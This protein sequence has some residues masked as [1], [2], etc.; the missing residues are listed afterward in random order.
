MNDLNHKPLIIKGCR[1]CGKTASVLKFAKE[2]YKHVVY[3]NF[4]ENK[5]YSSIFS[6]SLE[7]DH[8]TMMM[9]ALL[10]KEAVF[11]KNKTII[12]LDEIQE[13]PEARTA[14]KFFCLDKRYDVICTGSLLGVSGYKTSPTSIPV[15]YE[16]IIDMYPMDFEEFLWANDIN[17]EII[18]LLKKCLIEENVI[19]QAIHDR[20][21]QLLLQYITVGGMPEVV[22]SFVNNKN[23]NEV[24]N[25]QRN[26]IRSYS[27]DML[28]YADNK[29]KGCIKECFE[30]I[31]K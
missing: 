14:L 27:D 22:Q 10:G 11:E 29:D 15:G 30:S 1:Q 4:F 3:L 20:L 18:H 13:C 8:I 6:D 17:E 2:N 16:T 31:P 9:T 25:L 21:R 24:L 19:P 28:K 12:V 7:V 5:T 26:I 23:M